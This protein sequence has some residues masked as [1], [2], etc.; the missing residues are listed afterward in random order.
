MR[1]LN[2]YPNQVHEVKEA[3][4]KNCSQVLGRPLRLAL[5]HLL[6][7]AEFKRSTQPSRQRLALPAGFLRPTSGWCGAT[8]MSAQLA[9]R[10]KS[11]WAGNPG[12]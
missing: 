11:L 7:L 3:H 4:T 8:V 1:Y 10:V 12:S 2:Q 6:A 5:S 9:H